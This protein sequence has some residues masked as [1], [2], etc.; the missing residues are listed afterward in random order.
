ME[1]GEWFEGDGNTKQVIN[2]QVAGYAD[3]WMECIPSKSNSKDKDTKAEKHARLVWEAAKKP[4]WLEQSKQ[5][6]TKV[7]DAA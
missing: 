2:I 5:G 7:E 6:L 4:V 3:K 1:M